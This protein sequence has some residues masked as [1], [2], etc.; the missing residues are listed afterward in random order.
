M[1]RAAFI[2][3][4]AVAIL[5]FSTS[6]TNDAKKERQE[7]QQVEEQV[8]R[9]QRAMDSLEKAIEAQINEVDDDSLMK[10]EH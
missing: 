5:C 3:T 9:D 4:A 8:D 10:V 7:Q 2:F 6:C 1:K